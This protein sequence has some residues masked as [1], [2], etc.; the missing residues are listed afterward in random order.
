VHV[1]GLA[2]VVRKACCTM[3]EDLLGEAVCVMAFELNA[4]CVGFGSIGG[5]I[6]ITRCFVN[7][8]QMLLSD[9]ALKVWHLQGFRGAL[10]RVASFCFLMRR[11]T[12]TSRTT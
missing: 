11:V 1:A 8:G 9:W 3:N 6:M 10:L 5:Y 4:W 2:S 12:T 7:R